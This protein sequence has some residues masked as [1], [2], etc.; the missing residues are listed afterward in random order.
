MSRRFIG[1]AVGIAVVAAAVII[2]SYTLYNSSVADS[3]ERLPE[4]PKSLSA[5][6]QETQEGTPEE[7]AAAVKRVSPQV[8]AT[9][10]DANAPTGD[11]MAALEL[12]RDAD[13]SEIVPALRT[14]ADDEN[15]SIRAAAISTLAAKD[16]EGS[17]PALLQA[18]KDKDVNVRR[19]AVHALAKQDRPEALAALV[20]LLQDEDSLVRKVAGNVLKQKTNQDFGY[21]Y[22]ASKQKREES[23]KKWKLWLANHQE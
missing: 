12:A 14:A 15:A 9:L 21:Q 7:R 10:K 5:I 2:S 3:P 23:V 22:F 18:A 19:A 20:D 17:L 11:R 8:A 6:A 1:W 13:G 16:A 4:S